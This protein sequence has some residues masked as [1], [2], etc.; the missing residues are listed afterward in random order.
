MSGAE[1]PEVAWREPTSLLPLRWGHYRPRYLAGL[2]LIVGGSL[3]ITGSNIYTIPILI[4]GSVAAAVGWSILPAQGWRRILGA[5]LGSGIGWMLLSGPQSVWGLIVPYLL[6]LCVRH[7]PARSYLT[8][9]FPL[10]S[11]ILLPQFFSG[12]DGMPLALALATTVFVASAWLARL[13]A[14]QPTPRDKQRIFS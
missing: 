12:F 2:L 3:A 13:I 10:A 7:R 11:G 8:A 1:T 6:W 9:V 14:S 5:I 4:Q